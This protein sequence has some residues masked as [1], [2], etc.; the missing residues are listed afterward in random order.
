MTAQ[1]DLFVPGRLCLFGE[2]SDWAAEFDHHLGYCLVV[3]TD[4]GLA[5]TASASSTLQVRLAGD[6]R[7]LECAWDADALDA[8]AC[9]A[10]EFF[11]YCAGVAR[12]FVDDI[13]SGLTLEITRTDLPL[14]KGLASSAAVCM[15]MAKAINEIYQLGL[16]PRELMERAY[17][18]ERRTGSR[19]GRMDQ[20]CIFGQ[21]PVLLTFQADRCEVEPIYPDRATHLLVVDL[22]GQKDT[23]G[24]LSDLRGAYEETPGL[25]ETLGP[26]NE[27]RIRQAVQALQ[28]GDAATFGALMAEAQ[29]AFDMHVA[30]SSPAHLAAPIL[31]E[32]LACDELRRY[33]CGGKG[34][35][36]GGDGCAQ[37]VAGSAADRDAAI[38]VIARRFP[39]MQAWPLTISAGASRSCIE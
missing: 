26:A 29:Q 22:G 31:H 30:P 9:D 21:T 16:F 28:V 10:G 34:V 6:E 7:L 1:A 25:A 20:A 24:I 32:V 11:R 39:A 38:A 4:Q 36:S 3:G 18:G 14:K 35:G 17:R 33:V 27:Q 2:H 15:L 12:E 37:F 8:A 19:C 5:G 23:V 13:P